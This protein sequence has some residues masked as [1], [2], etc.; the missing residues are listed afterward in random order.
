MF[1]ADL[2]KGKYFICICINGKLKFSVT[3]VVLMTYT[4]ILVTFYFQK[5]ID[6]L[7]YKPSQIYNLFLKKFF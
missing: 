7:K 5:F 4:L 2:R 6:H 1:T 3:M